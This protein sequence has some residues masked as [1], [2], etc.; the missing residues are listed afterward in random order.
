MVAR[1]VRPPPQAGVGRR[2]PCTLNPAQFCVCETVYCHRSRRGICAARHG[3]S[4]TPVW[5]AERNRGG[6]AARAWLGPLPERFE[7]IL[8]ATVR[9]QGST[10]VPSNGLTI[11]EPDRRAGAAFATKHACTVAR[12]PQYSYTALWAASARRSWAR[13]RPAEFT[14]CLLYT[15]LTVWR[16]FTI[17]ELK[18][19]EIEGIVLRHS[20]SQQ[21]S[22]SAPDNSGESVTEWPPPAAVRSPVVAG[23][24]AETLRSGAAGYLR[25]PTRQRHRPTAV[26][27]SRDGCMNR[28]PL[29]IALSCQARIM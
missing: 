12:K 24:C 6:A 16:G 10:A 21:L 5:A 2:A 29:S 19:R 15:H 11:R 25:P 17:M 27:A 22:S 3:V 9:G 14:L 28:T 1:K 23:A 26:F 18:S 20:Q 13:L 8:G 7:A 4:A